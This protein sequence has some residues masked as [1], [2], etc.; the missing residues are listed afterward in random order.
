[1]IHVQDLTRNSGLPAERV[2]LYQSKADGRQFQLQAHDYGP[3]AA[4]KIFKNMQSGNLNK[5]KISILRPAPFPIT[6]VKATF[7]NMYTYYSNHNH[8]STA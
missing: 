1:M 8:N 7:I 5:T 6:D 4:A 2:W 3:S